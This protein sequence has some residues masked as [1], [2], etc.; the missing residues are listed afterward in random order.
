MKQGLMSS[1]SASSQRPKRGFLRCFLDVV[2]LDNGEKIAN[3]AAFYKPPIVAL[4]S[5]AQ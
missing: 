5:M 1:E 3:T 4:A 2:S